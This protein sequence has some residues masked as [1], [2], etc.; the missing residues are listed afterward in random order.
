MSNQLRQALLAHQ[1][2]QT[3]KFGGTLPR[4]ELP[5]KSKPNII[6]LVFT[7][8][9]GKQVCG[10]NFR[11][12]VFKSLLEKADVP[13]IRIHDI[14]HTFASLLLQQGE[15]LHYVKEQMG[16]ASIQTTVDVYGHIVPG[17]N[18]NAVNMLD[19]EIKT[20]LRLVTNAS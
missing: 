14:R 15:S 9:V 19:D 7:N 2:G 8:K 5:G 12:R 18:R 1:S 10:D 20:D 4:I 3:Q 13:A 17:S 11:K 6:R 16:H